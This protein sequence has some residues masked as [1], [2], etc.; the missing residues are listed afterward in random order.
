MDDES[1]AAE[2]IKEMIG[3]Q[4]CRKCRRKSRLDTTELKNAVAGG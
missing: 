4:T 1:K 2:K 3:T